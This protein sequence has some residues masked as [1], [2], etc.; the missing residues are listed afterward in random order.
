M[1]GGSLIYDERGGG[2]ALLSSAS[3]FYCRLTWV[4][5]EVLPFDFYH[6]RVVFKSPDWVGEFS[7]FKGG[8][9]TIWRKERETPSGEKE[10]RNLMAIQSMEKVFSI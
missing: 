1:D 6:V 5:K 4:G 10:N 3:S 9:L 8:P 2:T 7:L